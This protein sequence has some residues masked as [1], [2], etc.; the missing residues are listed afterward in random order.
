LQ[1]SNKKPSRHSILADRRV[2]WEGVNTYRGYER[3]TCSFTVFIRKCWQDWYLLLVVHYFHYLLC[4]LKI[5]LSWKGHSTKLHKTDVHC[6]GRNYW[7]EFISKKSWKSQFRFSFLTDW[8]TVTDRK[9]PMERIN[10]DVVIK[11]MIT[12]RL[13]VALTLDLGWNKKSCFRIFAEAFAKINKRW[14]FP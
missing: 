7:E 3:S 4:P 14:L 10:G 13:G 2:G 12:N 6:P 11:Q 5:L 9:Y 1:G 8:R